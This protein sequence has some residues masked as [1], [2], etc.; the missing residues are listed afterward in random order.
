[1]L[2]TDGQTVL[3]RNLQHMEQRNHSSAAKRSGLEVPTNARN[4]EE[5]EIERK[6]THCRNLRVWKGINRGKRSKNTLN[7]RIFGSQVYS[8]TFVPEELNTFYLLNAEA[9][10]ILTLVYSFMHS[11]T[12]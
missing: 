7:G 12:R 10:T 3:K 6:R 2:R 8:R 9:G 11:R 5:E 4:V 1:M